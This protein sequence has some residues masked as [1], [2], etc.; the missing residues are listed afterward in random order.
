MTELIL[1]SAS[2]RRRD[3]LQQ[4]GWQFQ[5][6]PSNFRETTTASEPESFVLYNALGKARE[7]AARFPAG[8]VLGADTIVVHAGELLG[9]P[10]DRDEAARMLQ[11]LA[12]DWHQVFTAIALV[13]CASGREISDVVHTRVH[14]RQIT[15]EELTRYLQTDE[16]YDKAG[17]YGIQG[18]A[19][20]FIDRIDG[21]Y[22]NVVGLP[23]SRLAELRQQL[24]AAWC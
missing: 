1:A 10:R 16:P 24:D 2:P 8:V 11:S 21:C 4:I 18:M 7:V 13:D 15:D 5:V 20:M 19:A 22:F 17:A 14:M 9:K 23:L 12:A 6:H 3:L